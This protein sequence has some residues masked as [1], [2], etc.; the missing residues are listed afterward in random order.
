MSITASRRLQIAPDDVIIS[1]GSR[2]AA[3]ASACGG[4]SRLNAWYVMPP[5][6]S[7]D[8]PLVWPSHY[9]PTDRWKRFFIGV[10]WLGPDLAFLQDFRDRQAL[11]SQKSLETWPTAVS[12]RLA[13]IVG[14]AL[15]NNGVGWSTPW[16]VPN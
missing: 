15:V 4:R 7:P 3:L 14:E 8:E 2:R 11:R 6:M 10:R 5:K 9:P 1:C 16:F 12:R 13:L